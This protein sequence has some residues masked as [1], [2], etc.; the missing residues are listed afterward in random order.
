MTRRHGAGC[1]R[2]SRALRDSSDHS[3]RHL[4][5]ASRG[6]RPTGCSR[7]SR[8]SSLLRACAR[9]RCA[10]KTRKLVD[11]PAANF[12][13]RR[14][15][16]ARRAARDARVLSTRCWLVWTWRAAAH[17]RR[18]LQLLILRLRVCAWVFCSRARARLASAGSCRADSWMFSCAVQS[19]YSSSEAGRRAR[20]PKPRCE[21]PSDI[22][23]PGPNRTLPRTS[24]V[25][26]RPVRP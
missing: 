21:L 1:Y 18:H 2:T 8:C 4:L 23:G 11:V 17:L 5:H 22:A 9:S 26:P 7:G 14:R 12:A 25:P 20:S 6:R 13:A 24:C 15:A 19:G 3:Q 10:W 16:A